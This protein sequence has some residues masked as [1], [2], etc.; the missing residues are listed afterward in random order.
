MVLHIEK[1]PL[2]WWGT[3]F[4][5]LLMIMKSMSQLKNWHLIDQNSPRHTDF[6]KYHKSLFAF[7]SFPASF[8][9]SP[10]CK[11]LTPFGMPHHTYTWIQCSYWHSAASYTKLCDYSSITMLQI[12]QYQVIPID[13]NL[14]IAT[15]IWTQILATHNLLTWK[16]HIFN[17]PILSCDVHFLPY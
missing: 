17:M 8:H 9:L 6:F 4:T 15:F 12:I 14:P 13:K 5:L 1:G 11:N 10:Y 7:L 3:S 2:C 16:K